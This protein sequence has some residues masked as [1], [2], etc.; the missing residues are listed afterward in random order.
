MK[1]K[2][3]KEEKE[4]KAEWLR[5]IL[6]ESGFKVYSVLRRVSKSGMNRKI[7][8][9]VITPNSQEDINKGYGMVTKHRITYFIAGLLDYSY[10]EKTEALSV[11]GSGMDMGFNVVYNLSMKLF[12]E[13]EYNHD[14][15][16]KLSNEW[17]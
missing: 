10:D 14:K 5:G 16:Y 7:D 6:K 13:G 11:S 4:E 12:N 8:F 9:Y 3:N 15:A 17:F 1:V 2:F